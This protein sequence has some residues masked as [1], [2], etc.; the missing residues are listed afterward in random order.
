MVC[1]SFFIAILIH[2]KTAIV[3]T[4]AIV[5]KHGFRVSSLMCSFFFSAD[6]RSVRFFF[7]Q[8]DGST[9]FFWQVNA[10]VLFYRCT[11][12][13][14]EGWCTCVFVCDRLM[15][16]PCFRRWFHFPFFSFDFFFFCLWKKSSWRRTLFEKVKKFS[17]QAPN[18]T[19][20]YQS[21]CLS[22]PWVFKIY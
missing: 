8:I 10:R 15:H 18:W 19:S 17:C 3:T 9:L 4:G 6:V 7:W 14:L 21:S 5:W 1:T 22:S 16:V 2:L 11:C 13:F 12:L 20:V